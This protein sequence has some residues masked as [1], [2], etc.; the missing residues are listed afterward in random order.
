MRDRICSRGHD[1]S[2]DN[3]KELANGYSEC[4]ECR[5]MT[6][7]KRWSKLHER[8]RFKVELSEDVKFL[9]ENPDSLPNWKGI[10]EWIERTFG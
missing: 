8:K 2:G 9:L 5:R 7:R 10:R 3:K 6:Q 1:V 4:M